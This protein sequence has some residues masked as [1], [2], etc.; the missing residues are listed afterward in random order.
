MPLFHSITP[1]VD[2]E[3][4]EAEDEAVIQPGVRPQA[5]HI[6][7]ARDVEPVAV[8]RDVVVDLIRPEVPA[9]LCR[10]HGGRRLLGR[11]LT[12]GQF[13]PAE[14]ATS[15]RDPQGRRSRSSGITHRVRSS[16]ARSLA[17]LPCRHP[18]RQDRGST[19]PADRASP[20]CTAGTRGPWGGTVP[21]GGA[22]FPPVDRVNRLPGLVGI[23][24]WGGTVPMGGCVPPGRSGPLPFKIHAD[25]SAQ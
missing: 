15:L 4:A 1:A 20:K 6:G 12:R 21:M 11:Y 19:P 23:T 16:R 2:P 25:V 8:I 22:V 18:T 13:G 24:P 10:L 17:S 7:R 14:G 3:D 9:P 5:E